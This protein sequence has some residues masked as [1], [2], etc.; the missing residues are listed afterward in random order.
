M[1]M[2]ENLLDTHYA[3]RERPVTPTDV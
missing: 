3:R 1:N 2:L